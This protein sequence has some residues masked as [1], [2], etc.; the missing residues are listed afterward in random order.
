ME[1]NSVEPTDWACHDF[2]L[3]EITTNVTLCKGYNLNYGYVI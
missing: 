2:L 1:I 3:M